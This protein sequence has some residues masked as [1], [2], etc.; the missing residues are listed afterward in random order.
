MCQ[1]L[2]T[3]L[4]I[5]LISLM[6]CTMW[7]NASK[8]KK[9]RFYGV[10][11]SEKVCAGFNPVKLVY[12]CALS[13]YNGVFSPDGAIQHSSVNLSLFPLAVSVFLFRCPCWIWFAVLRVIQVTLQM[14]RTID[15]SNAATDSDNVSG[16][17]I[18]PRP[19]GTAVS[20]SSAAILFIYFYS[21]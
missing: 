20:S 15:C 6:Y 9:K 8:K 1:P 10:Y 14:V 7:S 21:F 4:N 17:N 2:R 3:L 5:R 13:C 18:F 16:W 12:C 11:L 19:S